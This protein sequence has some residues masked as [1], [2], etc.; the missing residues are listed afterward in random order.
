M[1]IKIDISGARRIGKT[2]LMHRLIETIH[3]FC[4]D[5]VTI[6][7]HLDSIKVT[8][9]DPPTESVVIDTTTFAERYA[10]GVLNS[11]LTLSDEDFKREYP[12]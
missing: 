6:K 11:K 2:T 4:G 5:D 12:L 7:K 9:F 10:R 3:E 1:K 8:A